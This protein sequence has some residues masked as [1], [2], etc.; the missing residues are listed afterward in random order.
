MPSVLRQHNRGITGISD[1]RALDIA[2]AVIGSAR[3]RV[4]L[5]HDLKPEI[6]GSTDATR[7]RKW[8]DKKT[9]RSGFRFRPEGGDRQGHH[10]IS[11]PQEVCNTLVAF[12][13][14]WRKANIEAIHTPRCN[15]QLR[16]YRAT[17]ARKARFS[18]S[19]DL[20]ETRPHCY[21]FR[22]PKVELRSSL[23]IRRAMAAKVL[24]APVLGSPRQL[25]IVQSP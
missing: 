10:A 7:H 15:K 12:S 4:Y 23:P 6:G 8:F 11:P 13:L 14:F 25:P 19:D 17:R 16:T 22:P 2:I 20:S 1:A 3:M 24:H 5:G 9:A 21:P 18:E